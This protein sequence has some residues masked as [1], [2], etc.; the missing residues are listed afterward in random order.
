MSNAT[1]AR[2][3]QD[4]VKTMKLLATTIVQLPLEGFE[5]VMVPTLA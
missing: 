5:Y 4:M 3:V 2:A 1:L